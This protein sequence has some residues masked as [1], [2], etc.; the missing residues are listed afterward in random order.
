MIMN[1]TALIFG[2]IV[3]VAM[4]AAAV[5]SSVGDEAATPDYPYSR[6]LADAASGRVES[7]VQVG[8]RLTVRLGG[9]S[10]ARHVAVASESINVYAELCTAAG[11]QLGACPIEYVADAPS[12][13]EQWLGLLITSLLP[14]L[15]IGAFI[16]FMMR[17]A[18]RQGRGA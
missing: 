13:S 17:N 5:W 18:Q 10:E 11:A 4:I 3:A 8:T 6:L 1:R 15:L 2:A 9:E 7:V 12:S 16:F 14:V